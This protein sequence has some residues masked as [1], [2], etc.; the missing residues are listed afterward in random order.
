MN[1]ILIILDSL[2][3]DHLGCYGNNWI[4]TP[5]LDRFSGTSATFEMA[6]P[7]SLPTIPIRRSIHTGIR[8][9]PFRDYKI[10]KGGHVKIYGWQPI[11]D[12]QVTLAEILRH[13]GY[14]TAFITDVY[15]QFKPGM[16]FHRGFD[17]WRWIRGQE[18]DAYNS[19]PVLDLEPYTSE[20]GMCNKKILSRYL[21]NTSGRREERD[22]FGPRVFSEAERWIREN[23]DVDR[24]FL[25]I[26]SFDPHEPWDPPEKYV[27][28]YDPGYT[29]KNVIA[30]M[31]RDW[32]DYLSE[33]ELKHMKALYAAEVTMVDHWFGKFMHAL[34]ETEY[35]KNTLV[36]VISDHGHQLGEHGTTG[37]LP[38]G[39]YPELMDIPLII[40]EPG[41]EGRGKRVP[42]MVYNHDL[43]PTV[44]SYLD[45]A[46]PNEPDG[47]D[48][49]PMISGEDTCPRDFVTSGYNDFFWIRDSGHTLIHNSRGMGDR[50]YDLKRDP[51]QAKDIS[52]DKPHEVMRLKSLLLDDAGGPLPDYNDMVKAAKKDWTM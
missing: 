28:L 47:I 29:G 12:G 5:N 17:E 20:A 42:G 7:E 48:L 32:Q 11:P 10:P 4:K 6:Y 13:E 22:Y 24:F 45:I 33:D 1:V 14:R 19:N 40:S 3:R 34:E 46:A 51:N 50:L 49:R 26:D 23:H 39:L 41:G 36:A 52:E 38:R 8:T 2:R 25:C 16:N 35:S 43:F 31:Y 21:S 27:D 15:H 37:K 9:F 44:L 30:P 18:G